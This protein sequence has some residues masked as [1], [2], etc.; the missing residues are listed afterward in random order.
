MPL[1]NKLII[2]ALCLFFSQT[3]RAQKAYLQ[4]PDSTRW[5]VVLNDSVVRADSPY[6]IVPGGQ[7]HLKLIPRNQKYWYLN[8]LDRPVT[9]SPNDTLRWATLIPRLISSPPEFEKIQLGPV[10]EAG[11]LFK[12]PWTV[13][14]YFKP[15][16][17]IGAVASN[18]ASFYMKRRADDYYGK[19][20]RAASLDQINHYYDK[21]G[22]FDVYATVLLGVSVAAIGIYFYT[23]LS[24]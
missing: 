5:Q 7:F 14:R 4:I 20:Q 15:A 23:I 6:I 11:S 22:E 10:P 16:L 17:L 13:K 18:W 8:V 21:A 19:Y 24:D 12:K 9:L 2:L 3:A 1:Q